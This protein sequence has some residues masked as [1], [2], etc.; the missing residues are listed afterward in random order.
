[1]DSYT[2]VSHQ[3][4]SHEDTL[5]EDMEQALKPR[6]WPWFE[7]DVPGWRALEPKLVAEFN[8]HQDEHIA[9][10]MER[11]LKPKLRCGDTVGEF[12]EARTLKRRGRVTYD[13]KFAVI[14]DWGYGI[15]PELHLRDAV[16]DDLSR[17]DIQEQIDALERAITELEA[18][19]MERALE[20]SAEHQPEPIELPK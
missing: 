16:P 8:K 10:E 14:V 17:I 20:R 19:D 9:A 4:P 12:D 7:Y 13:D 2:C 6:K 5:A 11:A 3:L 15:A 1:M 18:L